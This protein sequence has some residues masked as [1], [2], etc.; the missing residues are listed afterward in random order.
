MALDEERV[1]LLHDPQPGITVRRGAELD[2]QGRDRVRVPDDQNSFVVRM[3]PAHRREEGFHVVPGV[4]IGRDRDADA[5]GERQPGREGAGRAGGIDRGDADVLQAGGEKLG[6][7]LARGGERPEGVEVAVLRPLGPALRLLGVAHE[8]EGI[9]R[10][11]RD[12]EEN[13]Q[14]NRAQETGDTAQVPIGVQS[15][16]SFHCS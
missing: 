6:A 8:I 2:E 10:G 5:V 11:G 9:Q 1:S 14:D 7:D 3:L 4:V 16:G 13:E 15:H 12:R